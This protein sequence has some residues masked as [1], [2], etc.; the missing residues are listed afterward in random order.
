MLEDHWYILGAGAI[1]S[2]FAC[3]FERA[4]IHSTLLVRL[5]QSTQVNL[6]HVEKTS[7]SIDVTF[8]DGSEHNFS[9]QTLP[10]TQS[11]ITRSKRSL[12][13]LPIQQLILTTKAH[14]S[15]AAIDNIRSL[16][17][18]K[19]IIVVMQ[20][21]M[22]VA[23]Q[24]QAQLPQCSIFVATTTEGAH[25]PTASSLIHAGAGE[26]W[27]GYLPSNSQK[28]YC[29]ESI[30]A[31]SIAEQWQRTTLSIHYDHN[32]IQRLW[33]KLAI[34]CAI[35]PL[36]VKYQCNNGALLK[37]PEALQLMEK[38]CQELQQIMTAR[39]IHTSSNLFTIVKQVAKNTHSNISSML[40]DNRNHRPTEIH[41]INGYIVNEGKALGIPTPVNQALALEI[42]RNDI[43]K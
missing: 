41:F 14:Q 31:Q 23:Q 33:T 8:L 1:G 24:L 11:S 28:D 20:N 15:Q 43:P 16:L 34:N 35:N 2:L 22:G 27:I 30:T 9:I 37:N 4:N 40:Q 38:V 5:D 7:R 36:T 12:T 18:E 26:T 25:R 29:T 21:G 10:S 39:G 42:T 6:S 19:A 13:T 17:A 32:I 3:Q